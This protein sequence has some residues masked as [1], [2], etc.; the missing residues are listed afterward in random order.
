M[1]RM[2]MGAT[3]VLCLLFASCSSPTGPTSTTTL[4]RF[5]QAL[6]QQGSTVSLGDQIAPRTNGFFSVPAQQVRVND[7]QVNAFVYQSADAAAA[8]A[9]LIS[10]D[11]QPSPTA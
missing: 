1:T 11:C 8:E 9:A 6:R 5:V 7:S 10:R 4:D 3:S 2:Q